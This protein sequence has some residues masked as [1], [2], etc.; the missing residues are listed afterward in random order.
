MANDV[1]ELRAYAKLNLSLDVTGK[2]PDGY[3]EMKMVMCSVSL[4]DE[5]TLRL[6]D[7]GA[8]RAAATLDV[9]FAPSDSSPVLFK[10]PPGSS[11]EEVAKNGSW[12]RISTPRGVGWIHK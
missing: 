2:R 7:D 11:Y 3:H 9:R 4:C 6:T 8:V 12:L 5:L 10:L 1:V